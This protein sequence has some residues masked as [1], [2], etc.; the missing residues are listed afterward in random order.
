MNKFRK[1]LEEL[2]NKNSMENNSNTSDFI[3]AEFLVEC[4]KAFDNA[5]NKR[6][7]WCRR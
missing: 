1:E 5:T 4:L 3:L 2:L 6:T 7:E